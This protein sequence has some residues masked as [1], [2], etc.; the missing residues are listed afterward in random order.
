MK[1]KTYDEWRELGYQVRRGEKASIVS[2]P[3]GIQHVFSRDQV[4]ERDDFDKRNGFRF[5][6]E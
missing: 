3:N 5:E 2:S 1:F 6:K 4:D